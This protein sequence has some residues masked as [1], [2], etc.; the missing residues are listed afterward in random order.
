MSSVPIEISNFFLAMQAGEVG[1]G[2]LEACFAEEAIYEEPFTGESR[3]H[4]GR[5]AIMQAM[6]I[7]WEL[8][9]AN[10]R[11]SIDKVAAA[12]GEVLIDWTCVSPSLPGGQG[13]GLNRFVLRNGLIESLITTLKT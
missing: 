10:A 5:A 1:A 7:G 11:I 6:A 8:P 9:V 12:D 2:A 3:T 13:S 4:K